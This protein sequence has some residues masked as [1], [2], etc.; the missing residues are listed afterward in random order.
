LTPSFTPPPPRLAPAVVEGRLAEWRRLLRAST[1][2]ARTVLQRILRS[3]L[4]FMLHVNP[5][6][7]EIDG[8]EIEGPTRFDRLFAGLAIPMSLGIDPSDRSGKERIGQEDT[9]D[10][11]YGR[12]LEA[13]WMR[14]GWRP[15]RD[16]N[17]CFGLER[18]TS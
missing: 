8:Y 5:L 12:V 9:F 2:R 1:S 14:K 10:A 7:G 18:A 3:R 6:S 11:D 15:Q 17:P 13:A 4:T 16:S